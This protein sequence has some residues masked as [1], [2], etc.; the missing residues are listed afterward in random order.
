MAWCGVQCPRIPNRKS[1]KVRECEW[2]LLEPDVPQKTPDTEEFEFVMFVYGPRP[3]KTRDETLWV[4]ES[5][6]IQTMLDNADPLYAGSF[7]SGLLV[8]T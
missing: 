7:L 2:R 1:S 4:A 5:E 8:L 6:E 3:E